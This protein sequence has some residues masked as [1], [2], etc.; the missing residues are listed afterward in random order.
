M[1]L[2]EKLFFF[3]RRLDGLISSYPH[4]KWLIFQSILKFKTNSISLICFSMSTTSKA[5]FLFLNPSLKKLPVCSF[6]RI[7]AKEVE[8]VSLS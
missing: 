7:V 5:E 1:V 8:G 6:P 4:Q 3:S 2:T